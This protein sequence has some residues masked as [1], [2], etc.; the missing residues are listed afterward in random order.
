M[1]PSQHPQARSTS[2][3]TSRRARAAADSDKGI[4]AIDPKTA[5]WIKVSDFEG[6]GPRVARRS[7]AGPEPGR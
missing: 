1:M 5:N 2:T 7:N 6:H 3:P 4:F